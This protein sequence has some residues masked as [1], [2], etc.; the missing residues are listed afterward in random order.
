MLI[1]QG[2][3]YCHEKHLIIDAKKTGQVNF[4]QKQSTFLK[5]PR[6]F[7]GIVDFWEEHIY[8]VDLNLE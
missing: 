2:P 3:S 6:G 1:Y 4:S 5:R 8:M 7:E